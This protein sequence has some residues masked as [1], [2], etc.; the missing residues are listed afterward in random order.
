M[1][2]GGK[3]CTFVVS[4]ILGSVLRFVSEEWTLISTNALVLT[5]TFYNYKPS[6][7]SK[8]GGKMSG[9]KMSGKRGGKAMMM[10]GGKAMMMG[11]SSKKGGKAMMKREKRRKYR[12]L[13]AA[14]CLLYWLVATHLTAFMIP[15]VALSVLLRKDG[16]GERCAPTRGHS[17]SEPRPQDRPKSVQTGGFRRDEEHGLL[18]RQ[19]WCQADSQASVSTYS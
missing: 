16:E 5:A 13:T 18:L 9:G 6:P 15:V 8:R 17:C 11:G 10:G 7:S 4:K 3:M 1:G 12:I 19:R 14:A 2:S